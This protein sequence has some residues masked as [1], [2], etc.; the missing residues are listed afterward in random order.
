MNKKLTTLILGLMILLILTA[1]R[2]ETQVQ[3]TTETTETIFETIAEYAPALEKNTF[4][5]VDM[6]EN[7][8]EQA[9]VT[10]STESKETEPEETEP[11][12][13]EPK[14]TETNVTEPETTEFQPTESA[15]TIVKTEYE[16][17][18]E[19]SGAEQKAYMET[20]DS[21]DAFFNWL[22]N[23]KTEHE[24]AHPSIEIGADGKID[25]G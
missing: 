7:S 23:A 12:A 4:E 24:A 13:T 15:P 19:M 1:C 2:K 17:Y 8:D 21:I 16:K 6:I 11:K 5:D 22:Q 10:N 14:T 25:I 3:S 18:M 9:S 20:F